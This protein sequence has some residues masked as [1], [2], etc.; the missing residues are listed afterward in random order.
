MGV[1]RDQRY[2]RLPGRNGVALLLLQELVHGLHSRRDRLLGGLLQ[3]R[4]ESSVNK[5][6]LPV[7]IV[8]L[9]LQ[10]PIHY[11]HKILVLDA[12]RISLRNLNRSGFRLLILAGGQVSVLAHQTQ[13]RC[14]GAPWRDRDT[15]RG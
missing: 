7:V 14:R 10:L 15:G 13:A 9:R 5:A 1:K 4:V 11:V 8:Q 2:L 12:A 3:I 6:R